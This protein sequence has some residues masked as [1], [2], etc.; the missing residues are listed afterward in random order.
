M[1]APAEILEKLKKLLRLARSSNPHEA[2]LAMEKAMALAAEHRVSLDQVNPD[3]EPPRFTHR[4]DDEHFVRL[5]VEHQFAGMIVQRFFRV[6]TICRTCL[7]AGRDGWPQRREVMTLVGTETDVEIG[8]YVVG[9]LVHHFRFCWRHHR[10]RCR[11]RTAF[12]RGM[13]AGLYHKLL[14]AEPPAAPASAA[15]TALEVSMNGYLAQHFGELKDR[16]MPGGGSE[17]TAAMRAG[18]RQ[19]QQTEIRGGIKPGA[20][21]PLALT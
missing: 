15:T 13:F 6:K 20:P 4:D 10:G 16:S 3:H 1:S 11:N 7:R 8:L 5:P 18:Y 19:G 14:S 17:A 2:A 12:M 9:F 21:A